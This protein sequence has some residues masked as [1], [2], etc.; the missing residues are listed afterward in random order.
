MI[1]QRLSWA[2]QEMALAP[3]YD[4]NIINDNLHHAYDILR[5]IVIAEE[6]RVRKSK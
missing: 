5:S 6:H 2:K 3:K 1:E 4:Y